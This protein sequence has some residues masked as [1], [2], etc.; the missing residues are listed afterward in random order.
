[1]NTK[2]YKDK[3]PAFALFITTDQ[4]ADQHVTGMP[5][6]GRTEGNLKELKIFKLEAKKVGVTRPDTIWESPS[7]IF[8]YGKV[9]YVDCNSSNTTAGRD[10]IFVQNWDGNSYR[11][12]GAELLKLDDYMAAV[13]YS[14]NTNADR[15]AARRLDVSIMRTVL[16]KIEELFYQQYPDFEIAMTY[17]NRGYGKPYPIYTFTKKA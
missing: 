2:V 3:E 16:K 12:P 14:I 11:E 1:M 17:K 13:Q 4:Q 5:F 10:D 7:I 6:I 9:Q 8:T 15:P